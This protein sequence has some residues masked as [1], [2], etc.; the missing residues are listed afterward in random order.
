MGSSRLKRS[1]NAALAATVV[2][3][4]VG[5]SSVPA[6]AEPA[7][8]ATD[9]QKQLKE[10]G[11]QAEELTEA[12]KKAQDD[13][14]ARQDELGRA[15]AEAEQ[16]GRTTA[17]AR[18]EE[19]RF[20]GQV[21]QFVHASYQ[22]ARMSK[23][24]ALLVSESPNEFLDRSSALDVLARD[25]D[26]AVTKLAGA[27]AQ[28]ERGEREARSAHERA[29]RAEADAARLEGEIAGKKDEM[30]AQIAKVKQ[31]YES[32]TEQEQDSLSGGGSKVGSLIGSGA[33]IKA[34]NAALSKQ[35]SPYVFGAKGPSQFDCSGL[36]QWSFK[37]AGVSL[38]SSTQS[39]I[40]EG[41][42][43]SQSEMKP[44]DVIFFYSSGSHDGIYLGNGKMVHA[45]T[46]GQTVTVEEV[47]YM[48]QINS[49]RRF[50]G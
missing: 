38:P 8:S 11:R 47:K 3:T 46:E 43:V 23:L 44:G 41:E 21:D 27:T 30:D 25:N 17:D 50:A 22:G 24:S 19:E 39:Q 40:S 4:A 6:T 48:G 29:A 33:A 20:R 10:L 15:N 42:K 45:P 34:V 31:Q 26:D 35:G 13:H 14:A 32:L 7:G 16:A 5:L 2:A 36:V 9:A 37:Q 18:A 49:V 12:Y 1:R 28:A